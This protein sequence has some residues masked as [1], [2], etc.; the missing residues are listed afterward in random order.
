MS[1]FIPYLALEASAGSGKTYQLSRRYAALLLQDIAPEKILC[2][3]FTNKAA[4][5]MQERIVL[6]L[7]KLAAGGASGTSGT[8]A[9]NEQSLLREI[10]EQLATTEAALT[11][12]L[13]EVI[14]RFMRAR[15][16]I[17]TID[18]FFNHILRQFSLN[19]GLSA[20]FDIRIDDANEATKA[21]L[22]EAERAGQLEH[23]V[24][25]ALDHDRSI[26]GIYGYFYDL[27]KRGITRI[28]AGETRDIGGAK[29]QARAALERFC[30]AGVPDKAREQT[31]DELLA[32][33]REWVT[34][35]TLADAQHFKKIHTP[36]LDERFWEFKRACKPYFEAIENNALAALDRLFECWTRSL[37]ALHKQR[38][39]LNFADV[40]H[41]VHKLLSAKMDKDFFYF[42]LDGQI[43]H[44]M[45][46]EFQ[47]TSIAQLEILQPIIEEFTAG[48]GT[49]RAQL[50]TFFYVGDK[51]QAIYAFRGGNYYLFDHL[52]T[53][54]TNIQTQSL[55][56]NY[57]SLGEL[58][59]F[60]N[61][62]FAPLIDGFKPQQISRK[63]SGYVEVQK[64]ESPVEA[65][66]ATVRRLAENGV[67]ASDIA[68]LVW[69]NEDGKEVENALKEAIGGID[70]ARETSQQLF[71]APAV[72]ALKEAV[73]YLYFDRN[74]LYKANFRAIT[75][76]IAVADTEAITP[77]DIDDLSVD[78]P[79]LSLCVQII[80]R[81]GL[82][83]LGG[84]DTLAF[85]EWAATLESVEELIFGCE[86]LNAKTAES[87]AA[88]VRIMTVHKSKGLQFKH[89]IVLER[90]T[91]QGAD[92]A[93]IIFDYDGIALK[94]IKWRLSNRKYFDEEYAALLEKNALENA[95][96]Q[97][98]ALYVAL[99]RAENSLNV[100][101]KLDKG[102]VFDQL[103]LSAQQIG[104]FPTGGGAA[105][106]TAAA[107]TRDQ[108]TPH[109]LGKQEKPFKQ[110]FSGGDRQKQLLGDAVHYALETAGGFNAAN[111]P[112]GLE[113]AR[114][115]FGLEVAFDEV[116]K[117][118]NALLNNAEFRTLINA[119]TR[120]AK[121]QP[122][123]IDGE[124]R[125]LDLLLE[126]SD[127]SV[128]ID[129]KTGSRHPA[130]H[131]QVRRYMR[132]VGELTGREVRG[133]LAY[134][135]ETAE[136]VE[137]QNEAEK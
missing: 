17:M 45:I 125:R 48:V 61:R 114:N 6:L 72:V 69:K 98:N 103:A 30:A 124:I 32:K 47:D 9:A 27:Y 108:V 2:L 22:G 1:G 83:A 82:C 57:R 121:E 137:V 71:A 58:V 10:A 130:H 87:A 31:I 133:V 52:K 126:M 64:V 54:Y 101:Q 43:E 128:I 13:P 102:A 110:E 21:F 8:N 25:F 44:L 107:K 40:S 115:R 88:G 86:S 39:Y 23:L 100:I 53:L 50:K 134:L 118:V 12:K 120:Y 116:Q 135:N 49:S 97:L 113:G 18:A 28:S 95:K 76:A 104:V 60:V 119:A 14:N 70:I 59:E 77:A 90:L 38:R 131:D 65:A 91:K 66:V 41:L 106:I 42:R 33:P 15:S 11:A 36:Q 93:K 3:T 117:R 37:H 26:E 74:A 24:N 129:Y 84:K 7:E 46:D 67:A 109:P 51:K 96:N 99:T 94:G 123:V 75:A 5:E 63:G 79:P 20:V 78:Q 112:L 4:N 111:A 89:L 29:E 81:L 55:P 80:D 85:L 105:A 122:I 62:T 73:K 92:N 127:H 34:K 35:T 56:T 68:I 19:V 16:Q 132:L 136:L